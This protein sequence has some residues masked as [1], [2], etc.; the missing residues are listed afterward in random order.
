MTGARVRERLQ[1]RDC[2]RRTGRHQDLFDLASALDGRI[3]AAQ[4]FRGRE[5]DFYGKTLTGATELRPRWKRCVG[6]TNSDLGEALGKVLRRSGF[7]RPEQAAGSE[8]GPRHRAGA[9]RRHPGAVLDDP[10]NQEAGADQARRASR[11]RL[12]IRTSGATIARLTLFA[13]MRWA[14]P[15]APT[16]LRPIA[17]SQRSASRS[18]ATSGA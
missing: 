7:R 14:M 1:R 9:S 3:D 10:G 12:A 8:H 11:T 17:S 6:S 15:C 2:Q 18:I 4:G 16:N 13:A 5:F